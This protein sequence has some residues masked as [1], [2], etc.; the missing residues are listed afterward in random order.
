MIEMNDLAA[1]HLICQ[2]EYYWLNLI[3]FHWIKS[4]DMH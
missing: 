2:I 1:I 3:E 4:I